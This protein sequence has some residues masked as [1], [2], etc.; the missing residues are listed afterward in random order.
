[1]NR[2]LRAVPALLSVLFAGCASLASPRVPVLESGWTREELRTKGFVWSCEPTDCNRTWRTPRGP[3]VLRT[4]T[5]RYGLHEIPG[6]NTES[7]SSRVI[8]GIVG[9]LL[10]RQGMTTGN[11]EIVLG[12]RTLTDSG[13]APWEL[14]CAVYWIDDQEEEYNKDE[15]DHVAR[16]VR[17]SEGAVCR[18]V[19]RSDTSAVLWRFR[20]GIAPPRDSLAQVHDSLETADP[21]QVSARPPMSLERVGPDGSIAGRY[22]IGRDVEQPPSRL[23]FIPRRMHVSREGGP[24]IAIIDNTDEATLDYS[25]DATAEEV[26]FLRLL[27]GFMAVSFKG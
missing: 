16:S 9:G 15:M 1:M 18:A 2:V 12:T 24:L 19:A 7:T 10:R 25:P 17:Q 8:G 6:W 3:I 21:Q 20:A 4:R 5:K 22:E 26:R 11:I 23:G 13:A 27:S 14:R